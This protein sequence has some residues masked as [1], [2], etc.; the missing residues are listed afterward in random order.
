MK[1]AQKGEIL[2]TN[3]MA[4]MIAALA[5]EKKAE[6]VLIMD[7]SRVSGM[8]D[9]FVICSASSTTRAKAIAENIELEMKKHGHRISH[10]EGMKEANWVLLDFGDI[11]VHIFLDEKRKYYSIE[12]LWGDA[13]RRSFTRDTLD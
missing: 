6:D 4:E 11:V 3:R 7:M 2:D 13:P 5:N 1:Q 9:Y 8:C 12:S 10:R